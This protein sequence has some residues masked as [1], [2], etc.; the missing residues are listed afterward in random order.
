MIEGEEIKNAG[1]FYRRLLSFCSGLALFDLLNAVYSGFC[2]CLLEFSAV[3]ETLFTLA[4]G[5]HLISFLFSAIS[6]SFAS[7]FLSIAVIPTRDHS[8][9]SLAGQVASS[10]PNSPHFFAEGDA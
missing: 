1:L 3:V 4:S 10:R 9:A 6:I 7:G 5:F 8:D 2:P